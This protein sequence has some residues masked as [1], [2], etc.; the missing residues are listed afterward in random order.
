VDTI[1]L[2][3]LGG[4]SPRVVDTVAVGLTPEGIA[5]SP[6]GLHVAVNLHAGSAS[7]AASPEYRPNGEV[8]IW[9]ISHGRLVMVARAPVGRWGQGIAWTADS[10]TLLVQSN[11]ERRIDIF[12]FDGRRLV[13][14]RPL[15]TAA[16]PAA[17]AVGGR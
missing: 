6:D 16:P 7:P 1:S 10:R 14:A 15:T 12:R 3:D 8:Q 9:R 2:I 4:A 13:R 11:V 5:V 17:L